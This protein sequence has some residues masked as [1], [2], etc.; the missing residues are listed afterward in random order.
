MIALVA[1]MVLNLL[2]VWEFRH[3]GLALATSLSA[4]LNAGLLFYG[5]PPCRRIGVQSRLAAIWPAGF[6]SEWRYVWSAGINFT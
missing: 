3:A 4:F 1:N 2:L 5:L 6:R